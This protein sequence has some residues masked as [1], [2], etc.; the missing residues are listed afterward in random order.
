LE[1]IWYNEGERKKGPFIFI[2]Y[3]KCIK[4]HIVFDFL[5]N[6]LVIIYKELSHPF[7]LLWGVLAIFLVLGLGYPSLQDER[8]TPKRSSGRI[9]FPVTSQASGQGFAVVSRDSSTKQIN[10]HRDFGAAKLP[11][12]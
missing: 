2:F 9:S 6:D 5:V 3:G 11:N 4:N 8:E 10:G 12:I 1:L 7:L